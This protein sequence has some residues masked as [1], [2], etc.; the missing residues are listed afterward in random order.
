LVWL[1]A[2]VCAAPLA[3]LAQVGII[4]TV[5]GNGKPGSTG[6][7][8]P[9]TSAEIVAQTDTIAVD[10]KGNLLIAETRTIRRVDATTGI[11]TTIAGGG[12]DFSE[13]IPATQAYM[14]VVS[15]GADHAGNIYTCQS[16]TIRKIDTN[17]IIT[18]VVGNAFNFSYSGDGGPALNA[19]M[20]AHDLAFDVAGNMYIADILDNRIRKVTASTNIISTIAGNGTA[21]FSGD[22]GPATS[23][24]L[25]APVGVSVDT[26]GNV[27][28]ADG[29][30]RSVRKIDTAGNISTV[31]SNGKLIAPLWT[32]VDSAGNV[33]VADAGANQVLKLDTSNNLS[34]FA[35]GLALGIG[36]SGDG[37]PATAA[38]IW[39]PTSLAVDSSNNVFFL[40]QDNY[41]V[42]KVNGAGPSSGGALPTVTGAINGASFTSGLVPNSWATIT[43]TNLSAV[44][45]TWDNSIAAGKLPTKLDGVSVT[46]GFGPAYIAYV[47]PTQINLIVPPNLL[48]SVPVVVTNSAGVSATF[49]ATAVA[50]GPAFFTWPNSQPVATR[51]NYTLAAKSG[52]FSAA[53]T[54]AAPGDVLILWGT[55]FGPTV[56]SVP[57]G[58]EVPALPGSQTYS[59]L[60]NVSVTI[61]GVSATVYGAAVAT[62]YAGLYQIAIQVPASLANGDWPLIATVGGVSSPTTTLTVHN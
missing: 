33:Y 36:F 1:A 31:I 12:A 13:G 62:G 8:G 55:G 51:Q 19:G 34:I 50:Y 21:G 10:S 14:S 60:G 37:G 23:A 46:I 26:A 20:Q 47:S 57:P 16:S 42:R 58:V 25:N 54:P 22:G 18:T 39:M 11:I 32:G 3:A 9:A 35:G 4:N 7:G 44:T 59:T 52:T 24:M 49:N 43:G 15:V 6:D 61:N 40:D 45:D 30:N 38:K 48:G 27:Y 56:P 41:R 2:L 53:T 5:A 17:G 29:L 28:F